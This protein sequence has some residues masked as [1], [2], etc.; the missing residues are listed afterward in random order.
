MNVEA[1]EANTVEATTAETTAVCVACLG[2]ESICSRYPCTLPVFSTP[3]YIFT[4]ITRINPNN[5]ANRID[6]KQRLYYYH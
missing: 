5:T 6:T 2:S 4:A 1:M 3:Y